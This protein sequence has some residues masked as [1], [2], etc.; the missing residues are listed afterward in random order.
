MTGI[1]YD[2]EQL[3]EYEMS[4]PHV[5]RKFSPDLTREYMIGELQK[6]VCRVIFKKVNGINIVANVTT[7]IIQVLV[8]LQPQ[9]YIPGLIIGP[10]VIAGVLNVGLI[11]NSHLCQ[12]EKSFG[13][14][15]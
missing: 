2:T 3:K 5:D 4:M 1:F 12:F 8:I 10:T 6:R 7:E 11:S 15:V 9:C 14:D 13:S